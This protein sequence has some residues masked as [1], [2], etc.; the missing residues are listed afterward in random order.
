MD[1]ADKAQRREQNERDAAL[2]NRIHYE[3]NAATECEECGREIG[4]ARKKAMPSATLCIR[5]Q[6]KKE[7]K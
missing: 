6:S 3:P 4:E 5:C 1:I 2:A 7:L